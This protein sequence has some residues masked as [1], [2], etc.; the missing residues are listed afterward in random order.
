VVLAFWVVVV[1]VVVAGPSAGKL[2][3]A[4]QNDASAWLATN[5]EATQVVEL[6]ERLCPATCSRPGP[7]RAPDGPVT[8]ADQAKAAAD[9]QRFAAGQDLAGEVL[10]PVPATDGRAVQVIVPIRVAEEGNGWERLA[11]VAELRS[12][13]PAD[14]E[15]AGGLCDRAGR[16][17]SPT[18]ASVLRLDARLLSSPPPS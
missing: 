14:A 3:S 9:P 7:L 15:G 1:V 2:N 4:Q 13:A 18:S 5:A 16:L 10:G 8:V 12:I 17:F 11:Q 6:A